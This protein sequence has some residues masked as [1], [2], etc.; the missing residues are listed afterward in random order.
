[1]GSRVTDRIK[2]VGK[3][4]QLRTLLNNENA[5]SFARFFKRVSL[6]VILALNLSR[7]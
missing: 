2:M 7:A 5:I 4:M 6:E 3:L 1:M